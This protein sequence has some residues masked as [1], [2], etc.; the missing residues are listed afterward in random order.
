MFVCFAVGVLTFF[1][2]PITQMVGL[3]LSRAID[4]ALMI[5]LE[6]LVTI[7]AAR[8][9]LGEPIRRHQVVAVFLALLGVGI[10]TELTWDKVSGSVDGR[11]LG[12]LIFMLSVVSECAYSV[13]AKPALDR[14]SPLTFLAVANLTGVVL[15]FALNI[16]L[17]GPQRMAGLTPLFARGDFFDWSAV[18]FL[19]VGCITFG[20]LYWMYVLRRTRVLALALT[21]YIQPVLGMV[22]GSIFVGEALSTSTLTGAALV[23]SAIW[24]AFRRA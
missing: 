22:W 10:L 9:F 23:F 21:L 19:G 24:L 14:R 13:L 20:Y 15:L 6:P 18:L 2:S 3:S 8:V 12:N 5:A 11:L 16:F 7:F 1:V 17:Y 4:G